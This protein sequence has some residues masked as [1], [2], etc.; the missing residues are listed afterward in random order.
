[1]TI[2][3]P[4]LNKSLRCKKGENL[5]RFL[6]ENQIP[7]ASSCTGEGVCG[8]CVVQV[9]KGEAHLSPVNELEQKLHEKYQLHKDQRICCQCEVFGDIEIRTTYW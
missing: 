8:K 3:L 1:M 4:Q 9:V 5:F 6:R 7:V 2:H